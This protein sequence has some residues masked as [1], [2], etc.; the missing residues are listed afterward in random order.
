MAEKSWGWT[1]GT[2]NDG[3]STY[4]QVDYALQMAVIAA[5]NA[6]EG[7]GPGYLNSLAVTGVATP[8]SVA[9]GGAVVDGHPY[10][11]GGATTIAIPTPATLTRIDR[12]VL[13]AD[14]ANHQVRITR[15]A[16]TEGG[17][18]PAITQTSGTTYDIKLAQVSITVG[19]VIT[20]TDERV[21]AVPP[22][23][24]I[25][26]LSVAQDTT[27][28]TALAY[29][30]TGAD[31]GGGTDPLSYFKDRNGFVHIR[32]DCTGMLTGSFAALPVGYRPPNNC[33]FVFAVGG[34]TI[35]AVQ[36][37]SDGSFTWVGGG[38]VIHLGHI[39]FRTF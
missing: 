16:G 38:N 7:V 10:Q 11:N 6:F 31:F 24:T 32:G 34:G 13:R 30:G 37:N 20:V 22:T 2:T 15:I 1:T 28:W 17:G 4:T 9:S 12:I 26:I 19:G 14:W 8:V 29:T 35:A 23:G 36:I 21:F 25:P 3:A 33:Q 18:A 5:C 27:A 39:S